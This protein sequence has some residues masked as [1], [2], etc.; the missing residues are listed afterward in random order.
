M[1]CL[2]IHSPVGSNVERY[3]VLLAGP[4]LICALLG[5]RGARAALA[6]GG[7]RPPG[8]G[9]AAGRVLLAMCA[10]ALWV[11]WGPVRE[12]LAV[13]GSE[14]TSA[15]YYTPVERYLA[16]PAGRA[17]AR[18]GAAHALALGGGAAGPERVARARLGEAAGDAL[19]PRRCSPRA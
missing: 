10:I 17:G 9:P 1:L 18:R 4:L 2:L 8:A 19:R 16:E 6:G 7:P 5:E 11:L 15:S 12:T 14:A 13:A 3:G